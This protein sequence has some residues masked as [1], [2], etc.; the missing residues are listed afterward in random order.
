MKNFFIFLLCI[1]AFNQ[2]DLKAY[3]YTK[4]NN[5][6]LIINFN[7]P[8]F[9]NIPFLKKLY[10]PFFKKI[11]FYGEGEHPEVTKIKSNKGHFVCEVLIDALRNNPDA[12]GYLFLEDDCI[13]NIWNCLSLDPNKI[14]ILPGF[15]ADANRVEYQHKFCI[16]NSLTN[17]NATEW[18]WNHPDMGFQ[19]AKRAF[20]NLLP[21]DLEIVEKSFG[22]GSMIGTA[23]DMLYIPALYREQVIRIAPYFSDVFVEMALP[24]ILS[25]LD[26]K[27]K[28]ENK[29]SILWG[30]YSFQRPW[31]SEYTCVHPLKLSYEGNRYFILNVFQQRFPEIVF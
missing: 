28:W 11:V 18:W 15:T 12:T 17:A 2:N 8:Y 6:L 27:D 14:W 22:K 26:T 10:S 4:L 16:A 21:E 1:W 25:C 7:H 19:Q 24:C 3:D 31:P 30:G 20:E 23:A 9:D 5:T 13:L 29:V